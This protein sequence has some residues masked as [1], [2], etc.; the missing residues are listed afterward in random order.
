MPF[1]VMPDL[2]QGPAN[3][4]HSSNKEGCHVLQQKS[5]LSHQA[6]GSK[7][8]PEETRTIPGQSGT[9]ASE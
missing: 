7:D 4:G 9:F 8:M 2:G 5:R 3:F 6:N 1:R